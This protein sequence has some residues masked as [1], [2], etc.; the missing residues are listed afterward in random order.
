MPA[1]LQ[2]IF[3][4]NEHSP[5]L[6]TQFYFWAFFGIV[7]SVLALIIGRGRGG[8]KRMH[9]RNI[10][11]LFV[12]WFFYYKTSGLF[13]LI[14]AFVTLS[15]FFIA[16]AIHRCQNL[17]TNQLDGNSKLYTFN[18]KLLLC[19]SIVIDLGLLAYFKYAY[20][21]TDM[22]N[23][24]FGLDFQVFDIFAYIG[25]GFEADGRF[26]VDRIILPVGI[27]FYIFQVISYTADVYH[28]RIEPVRNILDFGF[29]VS[30]FP[31][32]V[33]GPIVRAS[34]FIPQLYKPW[35]LTHRSF[36]MAVFWI[37]NGLA[38]KVIL[39]DYLAVNF[40]DRVFQSPTLFSGFENLMALFTY[41]MQVYADFSGYTD[42]AIGVAM[43]MGFYLPKN[44]DSPYKATNP[45]EFWRRWHMS[46]SRWLKTYL[47]IPLGGNRNATF[48]TYFWI[49]LIAFVALVLTG[50]WVATIVIVA[51]AAIVT[52]VAIVRKEHRKLL[53]TN[54]NSFITMLLGG[55]W[56]GAS[57]NFMIWG[58]LN[59]IGMII[60]KFWRV[61]TW[62][63]RMG[64]MTAITVCLVI[65][66]RYYP[67]P[68]MN[69]AYVWFLIL[70]TGTAIRYIYYLLTQLSTNKLDGFSKLYT[71]N[72]K[73]GHAWAIAQ[74]FAFISFTRLFFRS[75]SNLDPALENEQSWATAKQMVGQI[76]GAWNSSIIPDF[77]WEYRYV[78]ILFVVGMI[79]HWL[80]E[81]WKRWYRL[82]FAM[83][84]IWVILIAVVVAVVVIYQFMTAE[85][86]PFIYFQF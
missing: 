61:M 84:P 48:G 4:F 66:H 83:L 5:L 22:F 6:F 20:F 53:Y 14:L 55:L 71:L 16:K 26:S 74:T 2:Y 7:F 51:L 38:K 57:W 52:V 85:Q 8:N 31:Q 58:G 86:Q 10:F 81:R 19:L 76:G 77:L 49:A 36:G 60:N 75:S 17:S 70:W 65:G 79:I 13:L 35:H 34:E 63:V 27:S 40:I 11:L 32:L 30:F 73:L 80:P 28:K 47:Y 3:A 67:A 37:L 69:L 18:S 24:L 78:M 64:V 33:A 46:L 45:Q 56:H 43:L 62:H 1:A 72:S 9:L 82:N 50:S 23:N 29:Y 12:S 15:D 44:F 25:N 59:G 21:F 39:S 68:L 54:L 41:S 42:I